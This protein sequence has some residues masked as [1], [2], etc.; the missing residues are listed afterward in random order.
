MAGPSPKITEET[1]PAAT[2]EYDVAISFL[3]QDQPLAQ[4]LA[5][6]LEA[7]GLS[8]FFFPR[9]QEELAGTNGMESMRAPFLSAR[10]NVVLFKAP[11]SET[12]WTRV[13]D[14]AIRDRCLQGGWAALMFVTLDKASK[15]P[16][17]LPDSHI[18]FA[19][20]DYGIEQLIGAIKHRVQEQGG[21]IS[22]LDA[23]AAARSVQREAQFLALR[24]S[25][26]ESQQWIQ[27][28]VHPMVRDTLTEIA[29]IA[30]EAD[31]DGLRITVASDNWSCVFRF[32]HI[33]MLVSWRQAYAN[34]L[35]D[36]R[37]QCHLSV[38]EYSGPVVL[39]IERRYAYSEPRL[40]KE[41]RFR[42]DV[43]R[44]CSPIWIERGKTE[45]ILPPH[46]ADRIM[47]LFFDLVSRANR[48]EVKRADL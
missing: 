48:G 4:A 39:P 32:A 5:D 13:E 31:G 11:W 37:G 1:T 45:Q 6:Q 10:V 9:K 19:F 43:S 27:D 16:K 44:D 24:E 14:A 38:E 17:W 23:K 20:E 7:S 26:M 47:R 21:V 18:R 8:V 30:K 22:A 40:L 15:R 2:P 25:L 36:E 28:T 34:R 3:A 12:P 46:L 35:S 41:H 29:K 42:V 33:S